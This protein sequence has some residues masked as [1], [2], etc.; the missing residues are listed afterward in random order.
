MTTLTDVKLFRQL[1]VQAGW[2]V[3]RKG[4]GEEKLT[5]YKPDCDPE[6]AQQS[7]TG[8]QSAGAESR[9]RRWI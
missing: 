4:R 9:V 7:T 8:S 5:E 6:V 1:S 2:C 3:W